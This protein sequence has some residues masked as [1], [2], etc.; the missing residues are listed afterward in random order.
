[1]KIMLLTDMPPCGNYT[2]GIVLNI[3]CSFLIE[4]GHEVCCFS[5]QSANLSP[6]PEIPEDK[7][8]QMVFEKTTMPRENWGFAIPRFLSSFIG[9]NMTALLKLP[10]IARKAA[11]FAKE[12]KADFIWAV[13]QGQTTIKIVRPASKHARLPYAVQV[14]DPPS[15]WLRNNRFDRITTYFV[16]KEFG[17]ALRSSVCCIAA[18]WAMAEEYKKRY[19]CNSVP[20]ILSFEPS[21][22][23]S[24][25]E[26]DP[27]QFIIVFSGQMYA[28][29]EL[30][31]L[32]SA[33]NL[34]DWRFGGKQIIL[35]IYGQAFHLY[36]SNKA[37]I[38]LR[39]WLPSDELMD[40]MAEAD[41]LYCPYWFN[42][43]FM[44][45]ARLSFPSKLTTYLKTSLPVLF[46][47]PEYASPRIFLEQN[48]AAYICGTMEP[49][50]ILETLKSII[51]DENRNDVGER[52]Y[53]AFLKHLT[54]DKMRESFFEAIPV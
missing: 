42:P 44:E 32:I 24:G 46:H 43:V 7:L 23:I 53:Q 10:C 6:L 14:W 17:R 21:R 8:K 30:H 13:V 1:M 47:G 38:E 15:W 35:R 22:I 34:L 16:M 50:G 45:E 39:G 5:V 12:N 29:D 40:E 48:Q 4:A 28:S 18:S 27:S 31:G 20:V 41:L 36:F 2:A 19:N 49:A 25:K 52:G 3:L 11:R 51:A 9:N 54:L 33:L 37:R 26:K